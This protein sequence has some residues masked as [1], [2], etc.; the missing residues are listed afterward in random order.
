MLSA[1]TSAGFEITSA[2]IARL[3]NVK[4]LNMSAMNENYRKCNKFRFSCLVHQKER[5]NF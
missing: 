1:V 4:E 5:M 3:Q 2:Q